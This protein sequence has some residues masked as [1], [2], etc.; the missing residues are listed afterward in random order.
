MKRSNEIKAERE[1]L[2]Q[3]K[4]KLEIYSDL[5]PDPALAR[6]QVQNLKDEVARLEKEIADNITSIH[7]G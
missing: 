2:E 5:S 3:Y 1:K 4:K 6:M 7:T